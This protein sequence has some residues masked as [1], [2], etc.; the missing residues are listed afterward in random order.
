MNFIKKTITI[1]SLVFYVVA[2]AQ[3]AGEDLV[4]KLNSIKTLSAKFTQVINTKNK[5]LSKAH[6]SMLIQRPGLFRWETNDP[7]QL[8]LADGKH[9]YIYDKD[10]EQVTIKPQAKAMRGTPALFLSESNDNLLQDF[11]INK[12][13][14]NTTE[15]YHLSATTKQPAFTKMDLFFNGSYLQAILLEDNLGQI[16]NLT[17]KEVKQNQAI[18]SQTF[19]FKPPRGV[20]VIRE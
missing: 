12:E 4:Q 17:L 16:T 1:L 10:L 18:P 20:D 19:K 13:N 8:L 2:N 14:K 15:I 11:A 6:G 3:T 9:I 5:K 7:K